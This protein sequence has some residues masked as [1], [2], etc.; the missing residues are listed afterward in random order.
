MNAADRPITDSPWFW[1]CLFAAAAL[2]GLAAISSKYAKRQAQIEREFQGRQRAAQNVQGQAPNV[3]L[4]TADETIIQ[5]WPLVLAF[6]ALIPIA[7]FIFRCRQSA[8]TS[9]SD[10]GPP[11]PNP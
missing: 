6:T 7:W 8:M 4:S 3:K 5:L 9:S 1:V 11:T 10:A 2:I